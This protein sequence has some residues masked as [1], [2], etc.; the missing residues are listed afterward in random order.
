VARSLNVKHKRKLMCSDSGF[1]S[2]QTGQSTGK[3][4]F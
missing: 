2:G 1:H 3:P 4:S